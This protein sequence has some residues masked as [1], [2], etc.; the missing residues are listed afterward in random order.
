MNDKDKKYIT[1]AKKL[2]CYIKNYYEEK[3]P[4]KN[5]SPIKLQK[6]LYFCYAY[7]GGYV[8]KSHENGSEIPA[9]NKSMYLFKNKIEA[10]V[11]GPVIPDVYKEQNLEEYNDKD[12]F[13]NNEDVEEYIKSVLDEILPVSDFKLV[14][15]S[16]E[17]NCWK[18]N[19][20]PESEYH[21]KVI[22]GDDIINEYAKLY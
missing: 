20:D 1:D 3:F 12:I 21:N 10:W 22:K 18:N 15:V 11:Y 6:S 9:I 19:F 7:W 5:I 16:H 14:E 13:K 17:D 4:G 8:K 2:A